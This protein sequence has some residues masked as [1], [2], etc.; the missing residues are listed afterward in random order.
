MQHR[1]PEGDCRQPAIRRWVHGGIGTVRSQTAAWPRSSPPRRASPRS[2]RTG[3]SA[4]RG[5][6]V[7]ARP[8]ANPARCAIRGRSSR[9]RR[10]GGSQPAPARLP[11]DLRH[12]S[13]WLA[14]RRRA[15]SPDQ[16][17]CLASPP[18]GAPPIALLSSTE[19]ALFAGARDTGRPADCAAS[20]TGAVRINKSM[21]DRMLFL[22][23][24]TLPGN[25]FH[26]PSRADSMPKRAG[27][28]MLP[29]AA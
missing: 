23:F 21:H 5:P 24:A 25:I 15:G 9:S 1:H 6:R 11:T 29:G 17:D 14:C 26:I 22:Q 16:G 18:R 27:V 20:R 3:L 10:T 12:G 8:R 19:I 13:A 7:T 4:V 28:Q 2:S